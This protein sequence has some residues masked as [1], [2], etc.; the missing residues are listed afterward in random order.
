M[1]PGRGET[2]GRGARGRERAPARRRPAGRWREGRRADAQTG[3]VGPRLAAAI[4]AVALAILVTSAGVCAETAEVRIV[5]TE[6]PP[7]IDGRLDEPAWRDAAVIADLTQVEPAEGRPPSQATQ[8]YLLYDRDFLFIGVRARDSR[9]DRIIARDMERDSAFRSDDHIAFVVDTFLDRRNGFRFRVNPLGAQADG[10]VE[11]SRDI[12]D[13]WDGIWYADA[14]IDEAGWVAEIALPFKTLSFDPD[15]N[16]WGFNIERV[17]RRNN[18]VVRWTAADQDREL[19]AMGRAGRIVGISDVRQGIGLDVKPAAV[20]R[21]FDQF[22]GGPA[23]EAEPSLDV[24]YRITPSLA[25]VLTFNTDFA[26]TEVDERQINLDRF[27][28][29]FPE[30]RDFFLEDAGIF[31][32]GDLEQNGRPFFSRRIGLDD[33]GAVVDLI[34]GGKIT[35]RQ[36]PANLGFLGVRTGETAQVDAKNLFVART[37]FNLL[38]QSSAGFI[39][40]HGNPTGPESNTVVGSDFSFRTDRL[41]GTDPLTG[42]LWAQRA[43]SEGAD[44]REWAYGGRLEY[45]ADRFAVDLEFKELQENFR[46]RLGFVNR[47]NIRQLDA[48]SRLRFRFAEDSLFRKLDTG[49]ETTFVANA[50]DNT[51][52]T[53]ETKVDL[54]KLETDIGDEI[55]AS[56]K[57]QYESLDED[58]EIVD[59]IVIPQNVYQFNRFALGGS[60]SPARPLAGG[61]EIEG[62]QFFDGH[63]VQ[64]KPFV[65][66]RPSPHFFL[67]LEYERNEVFLPAGSFNTNLVRSRVV[68]QFSPSLIWQNLIQYDDVSDSVGLNSRL[69]WIVSPGNEAFF[70]FNRLIDTAGGMI[71]PQ[72]DRD[73]ETRTEAVAKLVWTFR[74]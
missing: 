18:E 2:D 67:A 29:F 22:A 73:T 34:A 62:G 39:V 30:K 26:E 33:D 44:G 43:F 66:W 13:D 55:N 32:F 74:F 14:R 40:T 54:A 1:P 24:T 51:L 3:A 57:F 37:A 72:I 58:F 27:D 70:V 17:I 8:V 11:N 69:R 16:S 48:A 35:G 42:T 50:L 36:G 65:D 4:V 23:V 19:T 5:R 10:L 46:P 15:G 60:L 38:E 53:N 49:V 64:G 56:Y 47:R 68:V 6:T 20:L 12:G 28:L 7:T 9:P 31:E 41:F 63:S 52:E 71:D 59:G 25:S 61:L 21:A 45:P